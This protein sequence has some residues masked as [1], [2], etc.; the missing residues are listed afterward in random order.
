LREIDY[1][2]RNIYIIIDKQESKYDTGDYIF[3]INTHIREDWKKLKE[4]PE[5]KKIVTFRGNHQLRRL[6]I[7]FLTTL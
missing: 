7:A 6:N 5:K 1:I 2:K 3:N 4:F